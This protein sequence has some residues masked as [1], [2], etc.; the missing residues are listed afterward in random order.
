MRLHGAREVLEQDPARRADD[1]EVDEDAGRQR[2]ADQQARRRD[3]AVPSPTRSAPCRRMTAAASTRWRPRRAAPWRRRTATLLAPVARTLRGG[4]AASGRVAR[5]AVIMSR[6][7]RAAAASSNEN[8]AHWPGSE[9]ARMR[10]LCSCTMRQDAVQADAGPALVRPA[11]RAQAREPLEQPAPVL[12]QEARALVP[13]RDLE[14][15][16]LADHPHADLAALVV[17]YLTALPRRLT[18]TMRSSAGS[19]SAVTVAGRQVELRG[20]SRA[21]SICGAHEVDRRGD[22][23]LHDVHV[24]RSAP[25]RARRR[26]CAPDPGSPGRGSSRYW[27]LPITRSILSTCCGSSGP[28]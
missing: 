18:R 5:D 8:S 16:R 15:G 19:H 3:L 11:G 7:G 20:A 14:P 10:P 12:G 9:R 25:A 26:R 2:R 24:R 27:P 6:A 1:E 23:L 22:D 17:P 28:R 21:W 13:H 4:L